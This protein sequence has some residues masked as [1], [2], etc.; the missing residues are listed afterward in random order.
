MGGPLGGMRKGY[1]SPGGRLEGSAADANLHPQPDDPYILLNHEPS[2][3]PRAMSCSGACLGSVCPVL[4]AKH[5]GF[6][7]DGKLL[8][9]RKERVSKCLKVSQSVS[10][11]LIPEKDKVGR[12]R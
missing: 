3:S 10:K 11:C 9:H 8:G 1:W 6:K 5:Q 2:L 12:Q 7:Q 4:I